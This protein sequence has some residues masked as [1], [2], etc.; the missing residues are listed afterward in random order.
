MCSLANIQN[1]VLKLFV[2]YEWEKDLWAL[3][4]KSLIFLLMPDKCLNIL[5]VFLATDDAIPVICFLIL[6][7]KKLLSVGLQTVEINNEILFDVKPD[8]SWS[9]SAIA[10]APVVVTRSQ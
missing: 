8:I 9:V 6:E 10:A 2:D 7:Q 3:L 1:T 4:L 5:Q